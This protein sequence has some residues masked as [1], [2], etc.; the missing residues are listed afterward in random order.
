MNLPDVPKWLNKQFLEENLRKHYGNDGIE[1]IKFDAKPT[2]GKGENFASSLY[3][4]QVTFYTPSGEQATE[5]AVSNN[6]FFEMTKFNI[7]IQFAVGS[8]HQLE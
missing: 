8:H 6:F 3:R 5:K 4:V 1:I 2:A 7:C